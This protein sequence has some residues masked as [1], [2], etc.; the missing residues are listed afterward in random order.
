MSKLLDMTGW[1]MIEHGVPDSKLTVIERVRPPEHVKDKHY[2]YWKCLCECGNTTIVR[3]DALLNGKTKSCGCIHDQKSA[4]RLRRMFT[5]NY[6]QYNEHGELVKKF[7]PTCKR[8]LNPNN[9][10]PSKTSLDKYAWE[11]KECKSYYIRNRYNAYKG[12]A[13]QRNINFNLSLEEFDDI[14]SNACVY[15]GQ[16]NGNYFDKYFCGIDRIDS[17]KGYVVSNCVAC[18]TTCNSMKSNLSVKDWMS[19]MRRILEYSSNKIEVGDNI[20]V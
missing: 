20:Y 2:T 9:F 14:T 15:C 16:Y 12:E 6:R 1:V 3:R 10:S 11:C 18:C 5:K 19:H 13:K 4:E 8:W 17:S 7:C